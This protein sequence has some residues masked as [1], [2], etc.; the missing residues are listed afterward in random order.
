[1]DKPITI[2]QLPSDKLDLVWPQISKLITRNF[3]HRINT[4]TSDDFYLPIKNDEMQ[5]WIIKEESDIIAELV[6]S[7]TAGFPDSVLSI[8]SLAG[9]KL[10]N[11]VYM[12]DEVLIN[13]AKEQG[14]KGY[15][16]IMR[17]GFSRILPQLVEDGRLY[18]RM[19]NNV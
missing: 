9:S 13:Y 6:T 10:K 5:L 15:E 19:V 2:T 17:H 16:A 11:W 1:M 8:V 14:C 12:M 18:V 3:H 7:V 4:M